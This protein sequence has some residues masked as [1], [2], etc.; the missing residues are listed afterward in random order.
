MK[1]SEKTIYQLYS[2]YSF[3]VTVSNTNSS[4]SFKVLPKNT[5][6]NMNSTQIHA[7]GLKKAKLTMNIVKVD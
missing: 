1:V 6:A 4:D 5:G 3:N 7:P 2:L